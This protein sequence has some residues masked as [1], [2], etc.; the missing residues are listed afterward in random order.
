M[1]V[2]VSISTT[3]AR[4]L[5]DSGLMHS[6]VALY[7]GPKFGVAPAFLDVGLRAH[8]LLSKGCVGYL[9]LFLTDLPG[10]P[11]AREVE[12]SKVLVP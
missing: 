6:F 5:F 7:I 8:R 3:P 1:D 12:F 4:C 10:K 2:I 11:P 9:A